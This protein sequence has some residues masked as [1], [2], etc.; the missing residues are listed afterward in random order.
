MQARNVFRHLIF[1]TVTHIS[2]LKCNGSK[3]IPLQRE[4]AR[5]SEPKQ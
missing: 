2:I 4:V 5:S 1:L 3:R